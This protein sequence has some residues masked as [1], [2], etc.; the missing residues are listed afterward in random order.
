MNRRHFLKSSLALAGDGP[1]LRSMGAFP[2]ADP[3]DAKLVPP[4]DLLNATYTEAFLE[5]HLAAPGAW[6]PYP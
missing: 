3:G 1:I 4:L 6:H 5:S 2:F